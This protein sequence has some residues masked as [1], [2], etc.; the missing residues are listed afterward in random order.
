MTAESPRF[1]QVHSGCSHNEK[2]PDAP[3]L[4]MCPL[5][6]SWR[7]CSS[8]GAA[9]HTGLSTAVVDRVAQVT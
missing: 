7:D 4:R 6:L 2:P 5:A 8:D 1:V 9:S 3:F